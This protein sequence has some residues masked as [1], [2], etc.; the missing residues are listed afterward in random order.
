MKSADS[1]DKRVY[2][3]SPQDLP[4]GDTGGVNVAGNSAPD[5]SDPNMSE[6]EREQLKQ[7]SWLIQ[8]AREIYS[9]ST[10]YLD[11]NISNTW[12]KNLAHF[13]SE[14]SASG[15]LRAK[16]Q[17]RTKVFRPKTRTMTKASEAALTNALFSTID[18]VDIQ[19][20]DETDVQQVVSAK[21]NKA[22]LQ[23]R[24]DRKMPWYQTVIGAY[25]STKVYGLCISFQY[26]KYSEDTDI[27]FARDE[28]NEIRR[29]EEGYPLGSM[30]TI[31]R[32]DEL[33]CD[34]IAPENFRFDPMADWR[35][36]AG[37]SPYLIY[38]MPIY[39]GD[40]VE[41]MQ[42]ADSK[43]GMPP[44]RKH[45][46][47]ALLATKQNSYDRT[48]Q[49]RE[50][51]K[52]IDPAQA[53]IVDQNYQT[54]WAHMN[55][56]RV[57]GDDIVYWTMGTELLLTEPKLL[58]EV[59]PHLAMGQRPFTVGFSTIE[60]FRNYP[61]GD[62]QQ[63]APLQEEINIVA[64]Q[65]IDNVK[66]ALNKRYFVKRSSQVDLDAL[67]RN[68]PGGGVMMNDIEKD[69]KTV[70]T[71]DVTS[72]SYQE[73]DRL[74][75]EMDELVGSFSQQS[76]QN[77]ANRKGGETK[78]GMDM[79]KSGAGAVQDYGIKIFVQTWYEPTIRQ[80]VQLE[81]YYE[82]DIT[83]FALASKKHADA[84]QRY[85]INEI[86]D[87]MLRQS[88]TVRVNVGMGNT[89]P[90]SRIEK[91]LTGIKISGELPGMA[92][93]L[94]SD[95]VSDEIFGMLGY[96]DST[97]FYRS[98]TEQQEYEKEHPPSIPAEVQIKQLELDIRK[99]DNKARDERERMKLDKDAHIEFARL[100]LE[101]GQT[102]EELMATLQL[103]E[104]SDKTKR[105]IAAAANVT[106]LE[107][108][109]LKRATGSGI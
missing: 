42:K 11:T 31:V 73:Q 79:M 29:D 39:A 36:P 44:W 53:N 86:T 103:G 37:T 51:N 27:V 32:H 74:S 72:S 9:T 63:A 58:T 5:N 98:E 38:M 88:L 48:R 25:Q 2:T 78:G 104:R 3:R 34:N 67:V 46:L 43:T 17:K 28:N 19:P 10:D 55:I 75:V 54:L 50:G 76:V 14:H 52:R 82:N 57:N 1:L 95:R 4:P 81:Q 89:D 33:C 45:S 24:L 102:Y 108:M 62:V 94:K 71:R 47:G 109:S 16:N 68:V 21:L 69:V 70:E 12:E 41:N 96:R 97:G 90:Q 80:L 77:T 106:K 8:K 59:F 22:M 40:A 93:R 65:R 49:A 64:N 107:E 15:K 91:L 13:N 66:L 105:D 84:L 60:A 99:E 18:V 100:A 92:A 101:K 20:E 6:E 85:K 56:V 61:S 87:E 30:T 26:W 23:Y 35:D 83:I 7:E